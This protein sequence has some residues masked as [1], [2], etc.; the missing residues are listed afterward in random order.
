MK[1]I[2]YS[3]LAILLMNFNSSAQDLKSIQKT[4]N[5]SLVTPIKLEEA[6]TQIDQFMMDEKNQ[7]KLDPVYMQYQI[8]SS[9]LASEQFKV[10]YANIASKSFELLKKVIELDPED[11]K[12]KEDRYA[13]VNDIYLEFYNVGF[14]N[15][16][17]EKWE[18]SFNSFIKMAEMGDLMI[19]KKWSTSTFDTTAY[20]FAGVTGQNAKK[21]DEA[22]KFYGAIADRD[23]STADYESIYEFL[24]IYFKNLKNKEK[25]DKYLAKGRQFY[26][27]NKNWEIVEI[28][29]ISENM[30][31]NEKLAYFD[32]LEKENKLTTTSCS[33]FGSMFANADDSTTMGM[34]STAKMNL[35]KKALYAF[36]KGFQLDTT[37]GVMAFNAA[38][39]YI[40]FWEIYRD[41]FDANKGSAPALKVKRDE[42]DKLA[43]PAADKSIEWAEKA[44]NLLNNK[45]KKTS[46]E[47][48]CHKESIRFLTNLYEYKREKAKGKNPADVDKYDKKFK[49]YNA[50]F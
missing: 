14:K 5:L 47:K 9:I 25:F 32:L 26:P 22:A 46:T 42:I 29:Y 27:K 41:R 40:N 8:Y 44:F 16:Q 23:I 33:E 49:F 18:L 11:K 38:V 48:N 30:T 1:K 36:E 15:Y 21:L 12:L 37:S 19:N 10:K 2:L 50:L 20:L 17:A 28:D 43:A 35:K 34:D 31:L 45:E 6:K 7:S 39:M 4:Y 3:L 13:G 24:C